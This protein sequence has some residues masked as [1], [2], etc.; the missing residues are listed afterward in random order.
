MWQRK[1]KMELRRTFQAIISSHQ[2]EMPY[3]DLKQRNLSLPIDGD[4]IITVTG[5][6]RCGKSSLLKLTINRLL[7]AGVHKENILFI[8]FD[9]ERFSSMDVSDFDDILQA[10]RDIYPGKPMKDVYL[11]FDEIQ[12]IKGWELFVLRTFKNSSRHIFITGSTA[13]MLSGEMASA[14]RGWPDEY[15]EYTL[16]FNEFLR[17]RNLSPNPYTEDDAAV[18]RSQFH[19]YCDIG[20]YPKAVLAENESA[21]IKILQ[22]YFNTMLFRDM[23]EHYEIKSSPSVVRYFLKRVFENT[24]K[25]TSVNNIFNELKSA[26]LKVG[27]DSLY[28][29][30]DYACSIFLIHKLPCYTRSL[31][32]ESSMPAKYYVADNGLRK[33]VLYSQGPDEGKSL[34]TVVHSSLLRGLGS[35]DRFFYFN[36]NGSECDFLVQK[37]D[38]IEDLVQV[39]WELTSENRLREIKG[40]KAASEATGCKSCRI[41]TFDQEETIV[42][43]GLS[44][45]VIPAWKWLMQ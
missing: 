19:Q 35:E 29:W 21:R 23:I 42:Q 8:E 10:Y 3:N 7:A 38:R 33:A 1:E 30:L 20:G 45:S 36:D 40:L 32:K 11:F 25:P 28:E 13:E 26:G 16:N 12:L 2:E 6:R 15:I 41:V 14:L 5:I 39:C 18:A 22:S 44:I 31:L 4:D 17:F 43:D 37:G 24:T 27:K 34:E 9:D